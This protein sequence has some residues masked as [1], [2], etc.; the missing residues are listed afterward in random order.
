MKSTSFLSLSAFIA[1][2]SSS[3]F[4]HAESKPDYLRLSKTNQKIE[5]FVER[6][7]GAGPFPVL[8]LIHPHQEWPSKVGAKFFINSG[9]MKEWSGKGWMTVAFSQPGY[10]GSDGPAD[11]C[12][13]ISQ[14]AALEMIEYIRMMEDVKKDSIVVYGGS[15]GAVLAAF[16]A[17]KD[18]QLAGVILKAGLYDFVDA[19]RNYGWFN[20]I[21]W[22]MLWEMRGVSESKLQERSALFEADKIKMPVLMLHGSDDDRA[23][24]SY[25][26][27]FVDKIKS[28]G[29]TVELIT[30]DSEHI[31][32]SEKIKD[33]M[34]SF[35]SRVK[36]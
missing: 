27:L 4:V 6:P 19:Y 16:A 22:A 13:P 31:I 8:L 15:R 21:K 7:L 9:I 11:F 18:S 24:I 34:S 30:F 26:K 10:G 1:I 32:S 28:G 5:F 20:P 2:A 36:R 25:A 23:P 12:G 33:Y 29:G 35:L 3:F 14:Q 17:E